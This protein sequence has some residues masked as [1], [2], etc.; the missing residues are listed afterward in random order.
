MAN[1]TVLAYTKDLKAFLTSC[2]GHFTDTDFAEFAT[3]WLSSSRKTLSSSTVSRHLSSL[4]VFARWA[5]LSEAELTQYRPPTPMKA[6]PHPIPEGISGVFKMINAADPYFPEHKV[7]IVLC[8][9]LG[10]RISEA[11]SIRA[12]SIDPHT[13]NLVV[14]GKGDKTRKVPISDQAWEG[15]LYDAYVTSYVHDD[16]PFV[17][18]G[19]RSARR[20]VTSL[21]R[22]AGLSR[23]IA[24]HDLRATFATNLLRSG[25]NVRI[26]QELLGHSS[27][28]VTQIYLGVTDD[29]LRAAVNL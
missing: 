20:T 11:L 17:N 18:I 1:N 15:W 5:G 25:V 2:D 13:K 23:R 7:L 26:I 12:S 29:E 4:K 16:R 14:R 22:R 6:N 19:N 3:Y 28:A 8:G 27:I 21:G 10:L 24:S 9:L